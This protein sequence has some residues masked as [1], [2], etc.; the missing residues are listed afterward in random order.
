[1]MSVQI[2]RWADHLVGLAARNETLDRIQLTGLAHMLLDL[3]GRIQQ[4]EHAT[5][6]ELAMHMMEDNDGDR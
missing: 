1:M 6:S 4:L 3:S 2:A 5:V